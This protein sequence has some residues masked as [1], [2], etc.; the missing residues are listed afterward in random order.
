MIVYSSRTGNV[1]HIVEQLKL[2]NQEIYDGLVVD[3]PYFLFT[4]TD[5]LG[6]TPDK[7]V[8]FL[9]NKINSENIMGVIATGNLNFGEFYCKTA[10]EISNKYNIPVIRKIDLRGTNEDLES[11]ITQYNE[12]MR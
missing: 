3:N 4:Y 12:T 5:G 2:P 1:K 7:I 8:S 10:D 6:E 11:I 9:S